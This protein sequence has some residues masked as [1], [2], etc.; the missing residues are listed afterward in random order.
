ME[1]IFEMLNGSV[2]FNHLHQRTLK[3]RNAVKASIAT[4]KTNRNDTTESNI[5]IVNNFSAINSFKSPEW[6]WLKGIF[7]FIK[8]KSREEE[9]FELYGFSQE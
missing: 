9:P 3:C 1:N 5:Y 4:F 2:I 6:S 8:S 7:K